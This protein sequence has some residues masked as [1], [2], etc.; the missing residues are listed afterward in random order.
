MKVVIALI[1]FAILV[2]IGGFNAYYDHKQP[3][4]QSFD[5]WVSHIEWES[6]NHN[7]P[8]IEIKR[9]NGVTRKFH[10]YRISL[11]SDQLK[12]GDT[13]I[14]EPGAVH[15]SINGESVLCVK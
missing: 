14:K 6:A 12:V 4:R 13:F 15:C 10:H 8:L 1:L 2:S 7:M 9:E 3:E 5:G 11:N